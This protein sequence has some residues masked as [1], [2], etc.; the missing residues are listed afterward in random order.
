MILFF[1]RALLLGWLP[2]MML[3]LIR[4]SLDAVLSSKEPA[5]PVKSSVT[6]MRVWLAET[7]TDKENLPKVLGH[8]F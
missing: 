1:N 2:P 8:G 3:A 6:A 7:M 4:E 5:S